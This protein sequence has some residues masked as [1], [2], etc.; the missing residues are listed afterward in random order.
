MWVEGK[1]QVALLKCGKGHT[2]LQ[3]DF[4]MLRQWAHRWEYECVGVEAVA[5]NTDA[6]IAKH[7]AARGGP[8]WISLEV[9]QPLLLSSSSK[10]HFIE[11]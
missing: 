7:H 1:Y 6:R 8:C 4:P 2:F 10:Y 5:V 3:D 9:Q 11:S